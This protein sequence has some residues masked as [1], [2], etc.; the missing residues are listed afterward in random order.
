M[1]SPVLEGP[2]RTCWRSSQVTGLDKCHWF[3][4]CRSRRAWVTATDF[5]AMFDLFY[6]VNAEH[7]ENCRYTF[8][9]VQKAFLRL[10][11]ICSHWM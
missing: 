4:G 3:R 9:V 10:A 11:E 6:T 2:W 5:G 7:P 8:K 1:L